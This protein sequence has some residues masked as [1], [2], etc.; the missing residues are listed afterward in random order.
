MTWILTAGAIVVFL[1]FVVVARGVESANLLKGL[2]VFV[3]L[4]LLLVVGEVVLGRS[5]PIEVLTLRAPNRTTAYLATNYGI[6]AGVGCLLML[7]G[8]ALL[9]GLSKK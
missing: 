6:M 8:L 9:M 1:V 2:L 7:R 5:E 3:V 4:S